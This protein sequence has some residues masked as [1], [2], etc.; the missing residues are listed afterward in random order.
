MSLYNPAEPLCRF[1]DDDGEPLSGGSLTV[2]SGDGSILA[3][4]YDSDGNAQANPVSLSSRGECAIMLDDESQY[5]FVLRDAWGKVVWTSDNYSKA[6]CQGHTVTVIAGDNTTITGISSD[7]LTITE[8]EDG[9][10]S[11][12]IVH[13]DAS[14]TI[15]G[16][17]SYIPTITIEPAEGTTIYSLTSDVIGDLAENEDG[18][19]SFTSPSE[20]ATIT[21][22]TSKSY[23]VTL[24]V[25]L[26]DITI[27]ETGY[28]AEGATEETA[29]TG[30]IEI[31]GSTTSYS[32]SVES[33]ERDIK[34]S[35]VTISHT[36]GSSISSCGTAAISVASGASVELE[37]SGATT[38]QSGYARAGLECLEGSSVTI[39]G[40]GALV[41]TGG[42]YGA[43]IGGCGFST[44]G[45]GDT[46]SIRIC[47]SVYVEATGGDCAAGIGGGHGEAC[48]GGALTSL[49]VS[50]DAKVVAAGGD[51]NYAPGIGGGHGYG[52][53]Q[54]GGDC[55]EVVICGSAYVDCSSGSNGG[56]I[57]GGYG[58]SYGGDL[59]SVTITDYATVTATGFYGAG[60][61]GGRGGTTGGD[62]GTV[63]VSGSATVTATGS[64]GAGIGGSRGGTTGGAGGSVA[65]S[66]SATVT[67][68][69]SYGAG[70][71]GGYGGT[72]A[73]SGGTVAVSGSATVTA[74]AYYGAGI[75]SGGYGHGASGGSLSISGFA[76]V[77]AKNTSYGAAV[78]G[79]YGYSTSYTGND[80]ADVTVSGGFLFAFASGGSSTYSAAAIGGGAGRGA[81]YGGASGTFTQTGGI[82]LAQ[83]RYT[84]SDCIGNATGGSGDAPDLTAVSGGMVIT[85]QGSSTAKTSWDMT[86][87]ANISDGTVTIASDS[88]WPSG[89]TLAIDEGE[90]LAI[91]SGCTLLCQGTITN[92]GTISGEV[93]YG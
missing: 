64:Y 4:V 65:I 6:V 21:L 83:T 14:L 42:T 90:T 35:C 49:E 78:G 69:G 40:T 25:S 15:T 17:S 43:G 77:T 9:T 53:G 85:Y 63:T 16:T 34:L 89:Y 2:Y 26:G 45:E 73:G 70:I 11:F 68:T 23:D 48:T 59:G 39:E 30:G 27:T 93:D 41:A 46:G 50:E 91:R 62:G 71:G 10:Y 5:T 38:L 20:D 51:A 18:S 86:D 74:T 12:P 60:I 57:G 7:E 66:G 29:Y 92:G 88:V 54:K 58:N 87:A 55:K 32:V 31:T 1:Y 61:G 37:L 8:N 13:E 72:T 36:D 82:V 19:W 47:G 67:A 80:G 84:V 81:S 76:V 44:E 22:S 28:T 24:D 79:G 52:T 3:D 75:G 56:G 33:G